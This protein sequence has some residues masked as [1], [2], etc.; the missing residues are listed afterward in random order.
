MAHCLT[1]L[2]KLGSGEEWEYSQRQIPRELG[3]D[4][5]QLLFLSRLIDRCCVRGLFLLGPELETIG[6]LYAHPNKTMG[7]RRFLPGLEYAS[8]RY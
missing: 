7:C 4:R 1:A 8:A 5:L 2:L 3:T 6:Y